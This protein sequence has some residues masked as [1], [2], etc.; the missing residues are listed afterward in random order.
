MGWRRRKKQKTLS[1]LSIPKKRAFA[2]SKPRSSRSNTP[3]RA[4]AHRLSAKP[5]HS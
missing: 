5:G 1:L 3:T 4:S 2:S